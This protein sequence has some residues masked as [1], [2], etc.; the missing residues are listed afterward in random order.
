MWQFS[1]F[2]VLLLNVFVSIV[3]TDFCSIPKMI[4]SILG[5]T[6]K[7]YTTNKLLRCRPV[8]FFC[9]QI[10]SGNTCIWVLALC[11]QCLILLWLTVWL[12]KLDGP[13]MPSVCPPW[14][15]ISARHKAPALSLTRVCTSNQLLASFASHIT[16]AKFAVYFEVAS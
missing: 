9:S 5:G 8:A 10:D 14:L 16:R 2:Y 4:C 1:V 13:D 6:L 7:V 12:K 3:I 15:Y 11:V